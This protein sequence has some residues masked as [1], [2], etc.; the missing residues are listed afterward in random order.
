MVTRERLHEL[1]EELTDQQTE[2]AARLLERLKWQAQTVPID[3]EGAEVS[4]L[5]TAAELLSR[6]G[7]PTAVVPAPPI[8]T[9]DELVG[10]FW[11][12]EESTEEFDATIRRWRTE[13]GRGRLPD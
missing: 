12:T 1:I 8:K 13:G 4:R 11:P 2:E 5:P 3:R 10:D 6:Y 9:I 7:P